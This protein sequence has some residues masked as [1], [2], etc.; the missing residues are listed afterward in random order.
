MAAAFP[1]YP[2]NDYGW[3][4]QILTNELPNSVGPAGLGNGTY[5]VHAIATN[6]AGQTTDIGTKMIA[7]DNSHAVLPFGTIDTPGIGTVA[8][9]RAYVNFGWALTP[10]PANVIPKDGSTITVFIDNKPV[11]HPVYNNNRS[12]I[13]S[14]FPG[15]QNNN[16][17]IG[18]YIIDTTTL[19]NGIHSISWVVSD[20]LGHAQGM[21]SRYFFVQN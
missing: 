19:T 10:N 14:L 21:G 5:K 9:G 7:A 2:Q 13:A 3:G 12:D 8:S 18:Y 17:A 15:L 16:G 6:S 4:V 11:G 20:N 1:G